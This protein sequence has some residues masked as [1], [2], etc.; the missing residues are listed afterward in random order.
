MEK[1]SQK[2]RDVKFPD[3]A[4]KLL[5]WIAR[6]KELT[7]RDDQYNFSWLLD[8]VKTCRKRGKRFR[9]IDSGKLETFQLEWLGE[10]GADLYSSDKARS[11]TSELVL[12]NK[13]CRR[14][15][16]IT[17]FFF[18]GS[19]EGEEE[20]GANF[21]GGAFSTLEEMGRDG[22][23]LHLSNR[24]RKRD[25]SY[26]NELAYACRRGGSW[27]VYY[28]FDPLESS[29][30]DLA[31]NGAWIHISHE[32]LGEAEDMTILLDTLQASLSKGT[33]L[34][35]HLEEEWEASKLQDLI[36]T[37]VVILFKSI[38]RDYK[39]PLRSLEKEAGRRKLDFR[40]YYLY[41]TFLP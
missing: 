22:I 6:G 10:A 37:G 29:L 16:G 36:K 4:Y 12:I 38:L 35:I 32:N 13:A 14:G 19:L 40:S 7:V 30:E 15:A 9:L 1:D 3:R 18:H 28:H 33:N 20:K 31:R 24:E 17:A 23:Y 41:P 26:L 25:F 5:S 2:E 21:E 39:S 11:K 27:L 8:I 34:I